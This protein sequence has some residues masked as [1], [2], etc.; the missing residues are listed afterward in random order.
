MRI[1]DE[2]YGSLEID[3][4]LIVELINSKPV[5]R[6]KGI[7]QSGYVIF[8]DPAHPY[9]KFK[10]TRYEHSIG[11][12]ALLKKIGASRLEQVAGLLHDI[13]HPVFAHCLDFLYGRELYHDSHE[14]F[15][16]KIILNSE[17]P[18]I[19]RKY[20]IKPEEILDG[21]FTL[22]DNE[23]P[24]ICADRID[25]SLRDSVRCLGLE[26]SKARS[27]IDSLRVHNDEIVFSNFGA[28]RE[29]VE[30]FLELGDI[31]CNPLQATLF[32]LIS[33]IVR[34]GLEANVLEE[35]DLFSEEPIVY[36]KLVKAKHK[37]IENLLKTISNLKVVEDPKN[38]DFYLKSKVRYVDPK[39]LFEKETKRVSEIDENSK[40]KIRDFI[41]RKSN[42]FYVRILK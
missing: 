16:Q 5:R 34:L 24:D 20:G 11:V 32:K 13:S 1:E 19:L 40:Q 35:E 42:G 25:Y 36:D 18:A 14:K 30:T 8:L 37:E 2:L 4:P 17:I 3:D 28:A 38:Y 31:Y 39:V 29:F 21:D 7:T 23:L 22:L 9:A 41:N 26:K 15:H 12:Y 27:M 10:V 6:L 33:E